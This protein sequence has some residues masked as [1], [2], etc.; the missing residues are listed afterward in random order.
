MSLFSGVPASNLSRTPLL[1]FF[2][3][4]FDPG[5]KFSLKRD[6]T[7]REPII[8]AHFKLSLSSKPALTFSYWE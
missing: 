8:A 5:C 3:F 1:S 6:D 4:F 7:A 2:S